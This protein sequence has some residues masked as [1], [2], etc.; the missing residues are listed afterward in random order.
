VEGLITEKAQRCLSAERASGT[1]SYVC[2]CQS[3]TKYFQIV[4]QL[5]IKNYILKVFQ[6]LLSITLDKKPKIQNSFNKSD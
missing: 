3:F 1:M 2:I 4:F 5:Q 6:L